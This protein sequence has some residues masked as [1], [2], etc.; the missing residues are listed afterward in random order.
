VKVLQLLLRSLLAVA[1]VAAVVVGVFL[2]PPVQTW[3]AQRALARHPEW[4]AA[5]GGC[6]AFWGRVGVSDLTAHLDRAVFSA[7]AVELR[8]PLWSA[9]R[10]RHADVRTLSAKGWIL[11]L[12]GGQARRTSSS[13]SARAATA[14]SAGPLTTALQATGRLLRTLLADARVPPALAIAAVELEGDVFVPAGRGEDAVPVHVTLSGGPL[15]AGRDASFVV[16]A[17]AQPAVGAL[18]QIATR[19]RLTVGLATSG[20]VSAVRLQLDTTAT[21]VSR[22]VDWKWTNDLA[23]VRGPAGDSYALTLERDGRAVV[24]LRAKRAAAAARL[25]G[26]WTA[27]LQAADLNQS[28]ALSVPESLTAKGE[29]TIEVDAALARGHVGGH[30]DVTGL[31]AGFVAPQLGAA[32]LL[33]A[34]L[35]FDLS[36]DGRSTR[37][38]RCEGHA[39][40]DGAVV[41]WRLLQP[42]DVGTGGSVVP[43]DEEADW[44]ELKLDAMPAAWLST[45]GGRIGVHAGSM[46]GRLAVRSAGDVVKVRTL[47]P[48]RFADVAIASAGA[49]LLQGVDGTIAG[50]AERT[51]QQWELRLEPLVVKCAGRQLASVTAKLVQPDGEAQPLTVNLSWSADLEAWAAQPLNRVGWVRG[52][53]MT[54]EFAGTTHGWVDGEGALSVVGHD[55]ARTFSAKFSVQAEPDGS[56]SFTA[57]LTM[58]FG[59]E[60]SA[61]TAKVDWTAKDGRVQAELTGTRAVVAH[62]RVLGAP[63]LALAQ[64][65]APGAAATKRATEAG[66]AAPAEPFWGSWIGR[67]DTNFD[68]LNLDGREYVNVGG[69]WRF[70]HQSLSLEGGRGKLP[71]PKPAKVRRPGK[72]E[73]DGGFEKREPT[74]KP[75]RFS[76]AIVFDLAAPQPY[77]LTGTMARESVDGAAVFPVPKEG[78]DAP[79][80]G[81]FDLTSTY[82]G[83]GSTFAELTAHLRQ[84]IKFRSTTGIVRLLTASI[85]ASLPR[86]KESAAGN[87]LSGFGT[88][89]G[90]LFGNSKAFAGSGE[91]KVS[92]PMDAVLD[93]RNSIREIGYDELTGTV[94]DEPDGRVQLRDFALTSKDEHLTGSGTLGPGAGLSLRDRPLSFTLEF[95]ARGRIAG[96]LSTANLLS[97]RNDAAGYLL[98]KQPIHFG[99][100][101]AAIDDREWRDLLVKAALAQ[102]SGSSKR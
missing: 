12:T 48:L 37:L 39:G 69:T 89:A 30:L 22:P 51:R 4:Q 28:F 43:V 42:V 10:H 78:A 31:P 72:E 75:V 58:A 60:Q 65:F 54:A 67:L 50:S 98:L 1:G 86:P 71:A 33:Q 23:L 93:F 88:A 26:E 79:L 46:S 25:A 24:R 61:L 64:H 74:P 9:L 2:L 76:G 62:L 7:P 19:G 90:W 38:E 13:A 53:S 49:P 57:P 16:T 20:A 5:I 73:G 56:V 32:G 99:G 80:E 36:D 21:P 95:G 83:A 34:A 27:D 97:E 35:D 102:P 29:G 66:P 44:L 84:E 87:A 77:R 8:V 96:L 3:L 100:T 14:E 63:V 92:K 70:D 15:A 68:Q 59:A 55:P 85:A 40:P 81:Y 45:P 91:I 94:V 17:R 47:A 18:R 101:L 52:R 41:D 82:S 11:D 6:S